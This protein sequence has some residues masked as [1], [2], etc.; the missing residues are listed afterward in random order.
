M[1]CETVK[2]TYLLI[3]LDMANG[4]GTPPIA[5]IRC[6]MVGLG[7]IPGPRP[8]GW[9]SGDNGSGVWLRDMLKNKIQQI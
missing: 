2:W 6:V 5:F 9:P 8:T 4:V 3:G 7:G 1:H